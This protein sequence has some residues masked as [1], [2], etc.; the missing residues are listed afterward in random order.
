MDNSL[1]SLSIIAYFERFSKLSINFFQL[2]HPKIMVTANLLVTITKRFCIAYLHMKFKLSFHKTMNNSDS[3]LSTASIVI[4]SV[5]S[6]AIAMGIGRFSFTPILPMMIQDGLITLSF[7]STLASVNYFGYLIGA[8][9]CMWLPTHWSSSSLIKWGLLLTVLL[10]LGMVFKSDI[11]LIVIR[12]L[13]GAIS[14]IVLVHTSRWCLSLLAV[15]GQTALGSI[16]FTGVGLTIALSGLAVSFFIQ[17]EWSSHSVWISFALISCLTLFY[18]WQTF[19]TKEVT[20]TDK[21][22]KNPSSLGTKSKVNRTEMSLFSFAYC[23]AGFGYI[24]TATFLP[25]IARSILP[26]ADAVWADFFWPAFGVSAV[27]G[28]ILV[29]RFNWISDPRLALVACYLLEGIGVIGA[30][31]VPTITGFLIS[32]LLAG[33]PFNAINFFTMREVTRLRPLHTAQYMGLLTALFSIG[34]I[35][36]PPMVN[37]LLKMTS[38][39]AE[40]FTWSL[41]IAASALFLGACIFLFLAM[42]WPIQIKTSKE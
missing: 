3:N 33:L 26:T 30:I 39:Q 35:A 23:L 25:I 22:L 34:Q 6:L 4:G 29:S 21:H 28:S 5:L 2:A 38:T 12:F 8:V 32:S 10:T 17:F 20:F 42:K 24:I 1:L 15:K 31:I 41:Q 14:A 7:G 37:M 19:N 9:L 27:I 13:A 11:A 40:G 16:M 18:I 36:G